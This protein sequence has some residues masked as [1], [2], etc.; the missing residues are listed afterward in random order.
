M[1]RA[2][3]MTRREALAGAAVF[4]AGVGF[5]RVVGGAHGAAAVKPTTEAGGAVPFYD[6]Y[7]AGIATPAQEF[8]HFAAFDVTSDSVDDLRGVLEQWSAAAALLT[9]GAPYRMEGGEGVGEPPMDTG[10]AVGLGPARLTITIG[11]GPSLFGSSAGGRF[12]LG[13]RRPAALRV[14][15]PFQGKV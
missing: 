12:G 3:G 7:Q 9:A 11:L 5:D 15:P 2:L 1:R 14:L 13:A 4:G 8:L 6:A 10:E